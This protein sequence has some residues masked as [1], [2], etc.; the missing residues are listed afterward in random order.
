[1]PQTKGNETVKRTLKDVGFIAILIGIAV[2]LFDFFHT[3]KPAELAEAPLAPQEASRVVV[4]NRVVTVRTVTG[5]HALYVPSS[6][7]AVIST[8]KDG[9]VK[10]D[11]KQ[12]G[13]SL[14]AG[15]GGLYADCPR[16]TLDLQLAYWRRFGFHVGIAGA[17]AHPAILPYAALSYR[18]DQLRLANTSVVVGVTVR[19]EPLI[20]LRVEL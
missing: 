19:K 13:V 11:V 14:E 12:T 10:L 7:H 20:G 9:D 6:G 15:F 4:E 5:I 16:L 8:K 2:A 1:M 17:D 3:E 18:L